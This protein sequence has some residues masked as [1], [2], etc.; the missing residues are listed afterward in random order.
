MYIP[1]EEGFWMWISSF[2]TSRAVIIIWSRDVI[3]P[4]HS[5]VAGPTWSTVPNSKA[6]NIGRMWTYWSKSRQR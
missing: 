5:A 1:L 2:G 3:L 6:Y 4:L